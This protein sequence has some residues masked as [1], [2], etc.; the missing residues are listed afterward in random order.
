MLNF[1]QSLKKLPSIM[2]ILNV[3]PDSFSGDG[4]FGH[5]EFVD[6]ALQKTKE[7]IDHGADIIDVGGEST[8]PGAKSISVDE[9]LSRVIPVI[10]AIKNNFNV[11]VSVDTTKSQVAKSAIEQGADIVNDV[12]GLTFDPQMMDVLKQN[13]KI[14]VVIMHYFKNDTVEQTSLG[15]RYLVGGI[16]N[17]NVVDDTVFELTKMAENA[18]SSGILKENII[19][20][21]GIGFGK[22]VK[23]NMLLV[24]HLSKIC[25][26]GY[27]ILVG[28]SRKSFIGYTVNADVS[29]RLGGS[30]AAN[31]LSYMNGAQILRV[32][33]VFETHQAISIFKSIATTG[34][35]Q[36]L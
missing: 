10:N 36:P 14:K 8:R 2:A 16:S 26:I 12:S 6:K 24:N 35:T 17:N 27:P 30:I 29:K 22:T 21:P 1:D 20:D 13:Q 28:V 15:G 33:D 7:F 32:H 4:I 34:Y 23:Q 5:K 9:E 31:I 19:L 25:A 3:T 11:K 18:L